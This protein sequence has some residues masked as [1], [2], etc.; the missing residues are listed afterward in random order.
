MFVLEEFV[1]NILNEFK[2][3]LLFL[4]LNGWN[5]FVL[6][7]FWIDLLLNGL[8]VLVLLLIGLL[9]KRLNLLDDFL[10]GVLELKGLNKFGEI[11]LLLF[12]LR[13]GDLFFV[14]GNGLNV[15]E[16]ILVIVNEVIFFLF[17]FEFRF[18]IWLKNFLFS[19]S[20]GLRILLAFLFRFIVRWGFFFDLL[21]KFIFWLFLFLLGDKLSRLIFILLIIVT[22]EVRF[23]F[24]FWVF[25][26]RRL[27]L[28]EE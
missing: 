25:K 14:V 28:F 26:L 7:F 21:N 22:L 1:L 4:E 5:V 16:F 18:F 8:N 12:F 11:G 10:F 17:E 19:W 23:V 13:L 3:V 24:M 20:F 9:A 27:I 15:G 2:F 6:L